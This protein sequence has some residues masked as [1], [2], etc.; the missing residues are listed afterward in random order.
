MAE[1]T[2][3]P[4]RVEPTGFGNWEM[5]GADDSEPSI[6]YSGRDASLS[7]EDAALAVK[8]VNAHDELVKA[9]RYF[10]RTVQGHIDTGVITVHP[11]SWDRNVA[12]LAEAKAV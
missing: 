3:R 1:P 2:A 10:M 12:I 7:D 9:G 11:P 8:C 6:T 5:H 4:W